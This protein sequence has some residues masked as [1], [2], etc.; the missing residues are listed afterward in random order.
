M[1]VRPRIHRPSA[2]QHE[3]DV[4]RSL[5]VVRLSIDILRQNPKPDTFLGRKT[6]E[7]PPPEDQSE[8]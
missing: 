4:S 3:A 1:P 7:P 2:V 6:Y 5:K 8:N